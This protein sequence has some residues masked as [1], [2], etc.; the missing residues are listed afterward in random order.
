MARRRRMPR[1]NAITSRSLTHSRLLR[2]T[3]VIRAPVRRHVEDRRVYHPLHTYRPAMRVDARPAQIDLGS[4]RPFRVTD[5]LTEHRRFVDPRKVVTCVR[6]KERREVLFATGKGGRKGKRGK[7]RR[8]WRSM[9]W[10][11]RR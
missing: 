8:D 3:V 9:I 5:P 11:G 4:R 2:P 10:C 6:R 1:R 7:T